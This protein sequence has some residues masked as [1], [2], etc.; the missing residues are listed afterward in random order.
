MTGSKLHHY[1]PQ[2]YL[3]RFVDDQT[4]RVWL[5]ER[6]TDRVISTHPK[7][8][9]AERRFYHLSEL[10]QQGHDPLTMETQLSKVENDAALVTSEWLER[11][12]QISPGD[13]IPIPDSNREAMSLYI[14]LQF[15]RTRDAREILLALAKSSQPSISQEEGQHLHAM[16]LWDEELVWGLADRIA[17]ASWVFARNTTKVP[18]ITSDNPVAFRAGDNSMWL[19]VAVH[20]TG[21]YAVFPLSPKL[22]LYCFPSEPPWVNMKKFDACLSPVILTDGMVKD[23]NTAQVFM[24]SRF[25]ISRQNNFNDERAFARTIGTDRYAAGW[26]ARRGGSPLDVLLDNSQDSDPTPRTAPFR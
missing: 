25:V 4:G 11:L 5:W 9:A 8:V 21:A 2:F 18:F 15:L 26:K 13:R 3:R 1:V 22:I 19:K 14:A 16:M 10:E 12:S 20:S 7:G 24:A 23:E 17:N 6:D